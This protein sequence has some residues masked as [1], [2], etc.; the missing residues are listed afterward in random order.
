MTVSSASADARTSLEVFALLAR[1]ASVSSSSS[2]MPMTP[3]MGVRI[4]WLMLA[5]NSLFARFA[6]SATTL[7][8]PSS[9]ST[10]LR[11][12]MSREMPSAPTTRPSSTCG[13]RVSS[14]TTTPPP[15]FRIRSS[16]AADWP[17][18]DLAHHAVRELDVVGMD[19]RR[20]G[21]TD[22]LVARPAGD[23]LERRVQGGEGGIDAQREHDVL[24][25]LEQIAEALLGAA[26]R[27]LSLL[28]LRDVEHD[29]LHQ[30]RLARR[31]ADHH[32]LVAEPDHAAVA[33]DE[34]APKENILPDA[35]PSGSGRRRGRDRPGAASRPRDRGAR[36]IP[37]AGRRGATRSEG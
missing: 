5:R 29:A 12:V 9:A 32:G 6:S 24:G 8:A 35:R 25:G 3:F 1:S 14:A 34:P 4:S 2:V 20:E 23:R 26:E 7:A 22:P 19:H 30:A 28:G 36:C 37:A 31:V 16:N 11:A 33:A 10:R 18:A 13:V 17:E 21:L 27:L 15:A